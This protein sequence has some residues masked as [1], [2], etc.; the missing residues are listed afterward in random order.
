[1]AYTDGLFFVEGAATQGETAAAVVAVRGDT[2]QFIIIPGGATIEEFGAV[3]IEAWDVAGANACILDLKRITVYGGS[4]ASL[5]TITF[6]KTAGA[7][8]SAVGVRSVNSVVKG[9]RVKP[10]E[11]LYFEVTQAASDA[12]GAFIPYLI[13]RLDGAKGANAAAPVVEYAA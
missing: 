13:L 8:A 7:A 10:G 4:G 9:T 11:V 5:G 12:G 1:M 6:P 2:G 3:T